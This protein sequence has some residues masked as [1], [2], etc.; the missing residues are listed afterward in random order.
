MTIAAGIEGRALVAAAVALID[1]SPERGRVAALE[2]MEHG[3]LCVRHRGRPPLDERGAECADD[4]AERR[5]RS[6]HDGSVGGYVAGLWRRS[7]GLG[8]P[9]IILERT[10][11]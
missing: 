5:R 10:W 7:R 4:V 11:M 2:G 8:V 6:A 9:A 1:V 3:A